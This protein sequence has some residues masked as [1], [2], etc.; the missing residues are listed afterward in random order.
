M[1]YSARVLLNGNIFV[2]SHSDSCGTI[3]QSYDSKGNTING[4]SNMLDLTPDEVIR[5]AQRDEDIWLVNT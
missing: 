1:K 4:Q 3:G 2:I 5:I